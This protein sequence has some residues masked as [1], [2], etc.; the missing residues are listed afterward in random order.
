MHTCYLEQITSK[1]PVI[2]HQLNIL[3]RLKVLSISENHRLQSAYENHL[4]VKLLA[5]SVCCAHV[6]Y[7]LRNHPK[8]SYDCVGDLYVLLV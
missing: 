5:V 3:E 8:K 7:G 6:A 2:L 4:I 1:R